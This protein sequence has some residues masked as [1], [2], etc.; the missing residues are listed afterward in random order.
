MYSTV[1]SNF[2]KGG[3]AMQITKQDAP[4]VKVAILEAI[5]ELE[6]LGMLRKTG[7]YRLSRDGEWQPVYKAVQ[8][9]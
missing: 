7:E 5:A 4:L 9:N 3:V 6:A 1:I 8:V 2:P